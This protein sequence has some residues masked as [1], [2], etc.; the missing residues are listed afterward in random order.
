MTRS[1]ATPTD[2]TAGPERQI[3]VHA[4]ADAQKLLDVVSRTETRKRTP[5]T[6]ASAYREAASLLLQAADLLDP[7]DPTSED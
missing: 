2:Q 4:L 5:A 7:T 3:A 6:D 1:D